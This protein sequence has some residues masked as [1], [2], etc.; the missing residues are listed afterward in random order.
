MEELILPTEKVIDFN[1]S[2]SCY[3]AL[4]SF[5]VLFNKSATFRMPLR[6]AK[7]QRALRHP[8]IDWKKKEREDKK[9]WQKTR[10]DNLPLFL[11]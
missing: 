9:C 4:E 11:S 1:E 3:R 10:I 8:E 7:Q 6:F 5:V 2:K